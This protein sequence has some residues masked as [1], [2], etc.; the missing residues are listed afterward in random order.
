MALKRV[1]KR[2]L[3]TK[4][5][6]QISK[7]QELSDK[8]LDE[9]TSQTDYIEE[10]KELGELLRAEDDKGVDRMNDLYRKIIDGANR[11]DGIK[12]LSDTI[13]TLIALER[14]AFNIGDEAEKPQDGLQALLDAVTAVGSRLPIRH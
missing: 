11:I 5:R 13:K 9:L 8:L 2:N 3:I 7:A 1:S 6:K 12:K 4:H 14:Q 10:L